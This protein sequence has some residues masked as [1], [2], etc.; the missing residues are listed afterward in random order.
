M[1]TC[2]HVYRHIC[3]SLD[4]GM[5]SARCRAIKRHL[6]GCS[7]CRAYLKS[8]KQTIRLYRASPRTALPRA[9]HRRLWTALIIEERAPHRHTQRAPSRRARKPRAKA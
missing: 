1:I 2:K 4:E 9:A 5:N 7:Q 8:L 3:E 6:S